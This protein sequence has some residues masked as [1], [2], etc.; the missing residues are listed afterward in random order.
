[1]SFARAYH[2]SINLSGLLFVIGG[3]V[4]GAS[5][6]SVEYYQPALNKWTAVAPM[7]Q[8]RSC[9][10]AGIANGCIYVFGGYDDY[11]RHSSLEKYD[12][13]EDKWTEVFVTTILK[14]VFSCF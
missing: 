12:P 9:L 2:A 11:S 1:M 13:M 5:S 6:N 4:N 14:H 3:A 7:N 8:N 10:Q